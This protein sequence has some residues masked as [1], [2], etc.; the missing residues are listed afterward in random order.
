VGGVVL[1]ATAGML[2]AVFFKPNR[3]FKSLMSRGPGFLF[4][5][6]GD[7][8]PKWLSDDRA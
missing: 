7:M 3:A 1:G 5:S 4:S 2:A 8:P 6:K